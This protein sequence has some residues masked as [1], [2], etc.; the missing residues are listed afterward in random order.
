MQ[1]NGTKMLHRNNKKLTQTLKS[2]TLIIL[3]VLLFPF[4]YLSVFVSVVRFTFTPL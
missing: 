1:K 3:D 4:N 2:K